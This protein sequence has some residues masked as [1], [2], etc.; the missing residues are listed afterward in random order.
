MRRVK[1]VANRLSLRDWRE[2]VRGS[3]A[4]DVEQVIHQLLKR[5]DVA[6][7]VQWIERQDGETLA[8]QRAITEIPS[9]TFHESARGAFLAGRF[10][11]LGLSDVS[12]DE[13]GNVTGR[14]GNG[15]DTGVVICSHLDTVFSADTPLGVRGS[16]ARLSAPG[17]GD[18]ARGLAALLTLAEACV[19][20]RVAAGPVTFVASVGEEADGD[21]RGVKALHRAPG[22]KPEAFI[23]LDGPGLDRVVHRALG[24]RRLRATYTGP[25]GHSWAAFGVP[26]PAHAVG[27][28]TAHLSEIPLPGA[29]R[30]ALSVVRIGGGH[31]L[32]T[33]PAEAFLEFD[34]RSESPEALD[35]LFEQAEAALKRAL[36]LV[37]RRRAQGTGPLSLATR[38][39]GERPSG[40][41]DE[42][43]PLVQ[44]ALAATRAV[45]GSPSLAAASTDA[46]VA[47]SRGVPGIA[48]GAGGRGG[49]AHLTSEW[50]ENEN[51]PAGIVRALLVIL[52]L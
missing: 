39:L 27:I 8:L 30:A 42:S 15:G 11:A 41:T 6:S 38:S 2:P 5:A 16:G 49:D 31:S 35:L 13:V 36:D 25:G 29:P 33:I 23:A 18:N 51:G 34:L 50:Y 22:F 12:T 44:A 19:K 48:L 37:N 40:T 43:H 32:N 52:A 47:I 1:R 17:I 21:L 4:P 24:S 46:N 7:A 3:Y 45:G 9:P 28:A 10:R 20:H 26:N 14:L